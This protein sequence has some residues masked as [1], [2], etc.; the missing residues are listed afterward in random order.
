VLALCAVALTAAVVAALLALRRTIQRAEG[1]L[2]GV[3]REL[4]PTAAETRALT[5]EVR[6]LLRESNRELARLGEVI[7]RVNT[8]AEGLGRV[9][10]GLAG[11]A[12][13]GQLIG[14]AAGLRKGIDVF[15]ERMRAPRERCACTRD[16]GGEHERRAG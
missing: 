15:V 16:G 2:G 14:L 8:V 11:F 9:A 13:A 4:A 5:Q 1:V 6:A 10:V 7:D 3:E 12:R